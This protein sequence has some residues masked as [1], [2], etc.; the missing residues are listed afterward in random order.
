[1]KSNYILTPEQ[2]SFLL[3][4]M[5]LEATSKYS[6]SWWSSIKRVLSYGHY[7]KEHRD[8]LNEARSDYIH[9]VKWEKNK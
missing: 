6:P 8:R 5:E 4:L 3:K 9:W 2:K 7:D 1:M